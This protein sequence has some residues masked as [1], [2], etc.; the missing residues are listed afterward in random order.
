M[1]KA[2]QAELAVRAS[3]RDALAST[4]RA[5]ITIRAAEKST[6]KPLTR[7]AR[8]AGMS[9]LH[10]RFAADLA[11]RC[12]EL[13]AVG[14]GLEEAIDDMAADRVIVSR[15]AAFIGTSLGA[16]AAAGGA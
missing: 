14:V 3:L 8:E 15:M 16:T 2:T 11:R 1:E 4:V 10:A 6:G 13:G 7:I 9:D 12:T 5:G